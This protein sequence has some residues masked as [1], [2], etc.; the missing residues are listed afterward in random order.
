LK[1]ERKGR[2]KKKK[3][4]KKVR[5]RSVAVLG[6]AYTKQKRVIRCYIFK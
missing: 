1:R 2:K 5:G 3:K 4:G 6:L